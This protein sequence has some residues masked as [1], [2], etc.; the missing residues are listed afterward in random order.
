MGLL[1]FLAGFM[2]GGTMGVFV[3]CL[4]QIN[5]HSDHK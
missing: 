5:R 4:F 2:V 1:L 3:M